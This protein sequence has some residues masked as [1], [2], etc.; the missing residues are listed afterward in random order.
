MKIT[1]GIVGLVLI[2]VV[3]LGLFIVNRYPTPRS[4]WKVI[5]GNVDIREVILSFRVAGRIN[6]MHYDEGDAISPGM[7]VASLEQDTFLADIAKA[8]AD[9]DLALAEENNAKETYQRRSKLIRMGAV[10]QALYDDALAAKDETHA[11][12]AVSKAVLQKATIALNDTELRAPS[13]GVILTRVREPGSVVAATE[14][15]Y[16]VSVD[17]PVWVRTYIDEPDLGLIYPGQAALVYTDSR[18]DK[19]YK[20]H[21]GYISP[22]AEFTPKNVESTQLRTDLVYR[23]R[24]IIDNTDKGLRQGMPVTVKLRLTTRVENRE[25]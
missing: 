9:V 7:V 4:D 12:V 6:H 21:V 17:N 8:Q 10:S 3:L 16:A 5:Y 25:Q 1:Q 20:G 22:Q 23:L 2:S 11:K 19:P 15:V 18:P 14:P 13:Q 24:I